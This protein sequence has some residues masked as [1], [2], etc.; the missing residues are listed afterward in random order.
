MP[1]PM[2]RLRVNDEGVVLLLRLGCGEEVDCVFE[3]V[4]AT[5]DEG[6]VSADR[7]GRKELLPE[8]GIMDYTKVVDH[9]PPLG[10]V[11]MVSFLTSS[12]EWRMRNL[13]KTYFGDRK[14]F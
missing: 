6:E 5:G 14:H 1:I 12:Q 4:A 7:K 8:A 3:S 9:N 13:N 10:R 11:L 2:V